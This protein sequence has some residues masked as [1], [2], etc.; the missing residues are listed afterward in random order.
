[1]KN[2]NSEKDFEYAINSDGGIVITQYI[3]KS[4]TTEIVIPDTING[5]PVKVIGH[6]AFSIS[7]VTSVVIPKGVTKIKGYAFRQKGLRI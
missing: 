3:G 1:M 4:G 2:N 6:G 7:G 5:T